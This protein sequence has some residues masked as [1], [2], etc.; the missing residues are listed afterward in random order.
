M[1]EL[2]SRAN[3]N[4]A[5]AASS[6]SGEARQRN[7]DTQWRAWFVGKETENGIWNERWEG[8]K[9]SKISFPNPNYPGSHVLLKVRGRLAD[10]FSNKSGTAI[11]MNR[12]GATSKA[13]GNQTRIGTKEGRFVWHA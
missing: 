2:R 12:S 4:K 3:R 5:T 13:D 10:N 1:V 11:A 7:Q 6:R 8:K 9:T